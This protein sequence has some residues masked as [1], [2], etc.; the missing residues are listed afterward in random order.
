MDN[1][2]DWA[3]IIRAITSGLGF[4][5][6]FGLLLAVFAVAAL[7]SSLADVWKIAAIV[8]A[9]I[10]GLSLGLATLVLLWRRPGSLADYA[11]MTNALREQID[12]TAL[13]DKIDAMVEQRVR[14]ALADKEESQ[15]DV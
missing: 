5:A 9:G 11:A 14:E 10:I 3:A 13:N 8:V 2:R 4:Y 7:L 12:S 1:Q 6:F 15:R